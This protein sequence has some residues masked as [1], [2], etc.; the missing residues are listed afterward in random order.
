MTSSP[1]PVYALA[2]H[3]G[4][5]VLNREQMTAGREAAYGRSL[6]AAL[7]AGQLV[8][9]NGASALDAV[10][11]AVAALEDDPLFNAGKGAALTDQGVAELDAAVMD[12]ATLRAGAV[13]GVRR[14]KNP[15]KLARRAMEASC[16]VFL[17]GEGAEAFAREQGLEFVRPEYFVTQHRKEHM[18]VVLAHLKQNG[19]FGTQ[20][21][22]N[23]ILMEEPAMGTVGAVALDKEG[24]LAA[25]TSTGGMTAKKTGRVG[26]SPIIGAGTYADNRT[27]AVSATGHGEWFIRTVVAHDIAAR[28]AYLGDSLEKAAADVVKKLKELGGGGGLIALDIEGNIAMPFNTAGMYRASVRAGEKETVAIY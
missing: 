19:G 4:A 17:A 6:T 11:A 15:V 2:I 8:L 20:A 12:G 27:C 24:G 14:V 3:G 25:A 5:G 13:T 9:E 7:R 1:R 22:P 21:R 10:Q 18:Q 28:M 23:P 16:H 26:D